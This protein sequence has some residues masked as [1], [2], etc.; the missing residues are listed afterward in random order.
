MI[1]T[2]IIDKDINAN[3]NY[4]EE[5]PIVP[6]NKRWVIKKF[7]AIDINNGDNKSSVYALQ[8]Y[9]NSQWITLRV[10][11]LSGNTLEFD[12]EK[13]I[14]GDGVK[15]LRIYMENKSNLNKKLVCWV[16]ASERQ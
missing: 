4:V 11:S 2:K 12:V 7:G 16:E 3:S 6:N 5:L 10:I 8:L 14:L 1:I 13:E 9:E 15:K